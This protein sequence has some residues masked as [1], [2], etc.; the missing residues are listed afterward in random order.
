MT[1]KKF[2]FN[3]GSRKL[4]PEEQPVVDAVQRAVAASALKHGLAIKQ[5]SAVSKVISRVTAAP[6]VTGH[7]GDAVSSAVEQAIGIADNARA[8]SG[9]ADAEKSWPGTSHRPGANRAY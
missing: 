1:D 2:T 5:G 4:F 8:P 9:I 7:A 3:L 6:T